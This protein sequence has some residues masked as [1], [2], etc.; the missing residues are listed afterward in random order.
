MRKL[1]L[2]IIGLLFISTVSYAVAEAQ[3][4]PDKLHFYMYGAKTCPHCRR[5]KEEIP[6]V[7]GNDSLTYYELVDNAENQALFSVQYQYTGIAGVPAIGIAY[8]GELKAIVEGE[9]NVSMAPEI[10][11]V[12]MDN[13]GLI[14]VTGGK[15]YIIKNA[16]IIQK[17]QI[18]YVE[19]RNP[20]E[21]VTTTTTPTNTTTGSS[22]NG[23]CGPGILVALAVVPL[24]LLKRKR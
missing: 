5:M 15:A 17:L 20:D 1:V 4:N 10:V 23:I 18:I 19:H 11:K 14:L 3:V 16:T 21:P 24:V 8:D 22:D 9:F 12:A 7:Y 2:I 6:R 13:G